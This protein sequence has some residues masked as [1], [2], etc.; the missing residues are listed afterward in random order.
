MSAIRSLCF[1]IMV[2]LAAG[3]TA[4]ARPVTVSASDGLQ[5]NDFS[6]DTTDVFSNEAVRLNL[7][8]E[9]IGGTTAQNINAVL[10]GS[11]RSWENV[12][13]GAQKLADA[14]TPP[15]LGSGSPGDMSKRIWTMTAPYLPQGLS[16][17]YPIGVRV[18]YDY[19]TTSI[20]SFD[21]I[22]YDQF[23]LLRKKGEFA[24]MD[25]VSGNS[26]APVKVQLTASSPMRPRIRCA[27]DALNC[28]SETVTLTLSNVGSGVPFKKGSNLE[29]PVSDDIGVVMLGIRSSGGHLECDTGVKREDSEETT[30]I[31]SSGLDVMPEKK[32]LKLTRGFGSVR[33]PCTFLMKGSE[34]TSGVPKDTITVEIVA[35]YSYAID[36][37][38]NVKVTSNE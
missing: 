29:D 24:Q 36:K 9:N 28:I 30:K 26:N 32:E 14:M 15:L 22:N 5:I 21:V 10:F 23:D 34:V 19:T 33:I 3:C 25:S 20:T 1:I 18:G 6:A 31:T 7:E 2:I 37:T 4:S 13:S 16:Q 12:P 38:L 17:D 11:V 8:V 27:E 35:D